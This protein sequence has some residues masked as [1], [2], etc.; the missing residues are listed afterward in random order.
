MISAH[1]AERFARL[2]DGFLFSGGQ[3]VHPSVYGAQ[4]IPGGLITCPKR[5]YL[6]TT[7]LQAALAAGE[8]FSLGCPVA[9]RV[10]LQ[11]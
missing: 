7:V 9:S 4:E 11:S 1:E 5:D 6:E 2:C 3:D 8:P 10:S